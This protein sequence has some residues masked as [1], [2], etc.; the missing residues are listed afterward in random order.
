MT[1]LA[2]AKVSSALSRKENFTTPNGSNCCNIEAQQIRRSRL[3]NYSL[4]QTLHRVQDH[5][6]SILNCWLYGKSTMASF[7]F[8]L[9]GMAKEL[10]YSSSMT[11]A[12]SVMLTTIF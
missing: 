2:K 7:L 4:P 3:H 5:D 8:L 10:L 9:R 6:C 11:V 12:R 1:D